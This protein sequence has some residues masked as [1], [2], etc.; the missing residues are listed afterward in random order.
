MK[1]KIAFRKALADKQLLGGALPGDSW[2]AWRIMLI[3]A[4]GEALTDEERVVFKQLTGREREPL[5]RVEEAAFVV[6]RRGGKSRAMATLA[7]YLAG[8]CEHNLVRGER[9]VCLCIAPD[10]R[11]AGIVLDYCEAAF[12]ESRILKQLIANRTAD[13]LELTNRITVEVRAASFRRLR[14][15]TYCAVLL[16]EGAYLYSDEWSSNADVEIVNAVRPGLLT[17]RGPL[18]IASSPYAR[19]GVLWTAFRK[20]FGAAGD[21][22]ILVA[23]GASR[24]L[25][26]SLPQA[27]IDR[28]YEK[29][30]VSAAAE[31]G[32]AFR[33]DI[34]S[35]VPIEV[36]ERCVGDYAERAPL[37]EHVYYGFVDPSG[38]SNDA[39]T[40]SIS[41]GEGTSIV[42]DAVREVRPPFSPEAV[43]ADFAALLKSYR[44]RQVCG[45][46]YAGEFPR[47]LFRRHGIGYVLAQKPKSD[48]YRD[49][50][51][52]LN[53]VRVVLPRSE[54]LISQL[55][56]L[57]RRTTRA[58]K[59]SIDHAP[60][61]HDDLINSVAGA[62][63]IVVRR[64]PDEDLPAWYRFLIPTGGDPVERRR[65]AEAEAV[66]I[67]ARRAARLAAR[68]GAGG[69][70]A[71][72]AAAAQNVANGSAPCTIEFPPEPVEPYPGAFRARRF[73]S[74]SADAHAGFF[75]LSE[76]G[77][78]PER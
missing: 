28:E 1:P 43:V 15:P 27:V 46:W 72:W 71:E 25:N 31:Y 52:L 63:D 24:D 7:A 32:A 45:D 61:A 53:S 74:E 55:V 66:Q 9:G 47:E 41:H 5:Q 26:P 70:D 18:I 33:S 39:F 51:P 42:I 58:G 44:V 4:M 54:R 23:R 8:L 75:I 3:A 20:H 38:G 48:L 60:G 16:D 14:G 34:E 56:G 30:P 76:S 13:T 78:R 57:V 65:R 6:G 50:L 12:T 2:R 64:D 29:D 49:L 19:R 73:A 35:F 22:L 69:T 62:A 77:E 40:L 59:D 21:P 10:Q 37:L 11:Q 68:Q 17:T 67:R 36:A